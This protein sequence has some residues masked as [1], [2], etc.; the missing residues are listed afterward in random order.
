MSVTA[1]SANQLDAFEQLEIEWE[2]DEGT[3]WCY[4]APKPRQCFTPRLLDEIKRV[5]S[6]LKHIGIDAQASIQQ[7]VFIVFASR[8]PGTF[9]LGGD[10]NLFRTL[11]NGRNRKGL[12]LYARSCI[13][14]VYKV[15]TGYGLPVTTISLVQGTALG[16]GMEGAMAANMMVAERGVQ[17]GLPE[18]LFNLFP[19]MGAYSFLSRRLGA[20][21]TERVILSGR[22]WSTE[23]LHELGIVDLL[24][25]PG[26]GQRAV[27]EYI[28]ERRRRS[29]NTMM[30]LQRVRQAVQ[31][32]S[33]QELEDVAMI[34]VDAA[35]QLSERDLKI[36]DRLIRS[37]NRAGIPQKFAHAS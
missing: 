4:M 15:S 19:G 14:A 34:W 32:V 35:M 18:V 13:E 29:P 11:I 2:P 36:M 20:A 1:S 24:A 25:E 17:M 37:Q 33:F 31:P 26:Q 22:T 8:V 7:P 21:E 16:G 3:L 30:A 9:N 28:A 6:F 10:L 12:E 5:P 27:R 23:E